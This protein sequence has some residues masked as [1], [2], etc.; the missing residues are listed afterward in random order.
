LAIYEPTLD[1]HTQATTGIFETYDPPPPEGQRPVPLVSLDPEPKTS[2]KPRQRPLERGYVFRRHAA[3]AQ[4]V[5]DWLLKRCPDERL[6]DRV[7]ACGTDAWID[8]SPS[9]GRFRIR[10]TRCGWRACPL[11]RVRWTMQ[12]R[13]RINSVVADVGAGRRKLATLTTRSTAAPLRLQVDR[14]WQCF[15]RLRQRRLWTSAVA[16]SIAVLEVT[17]NAKTDRWH[18]H[19]HVILDA[20]YIEQRALSKAWLSVTLTSRIVD[21]RAVRS[22]GDV[23][24]YLTKYL[25]KTCELPAGTP[26]ERDDELFALY[27]RHRFTRYAGT[28]RPRPDEELWRPDYPKDWQPVAVLEL[29]LEGAARQ[30]ARALAILDAVAR[31][32]LFASRDYLQ[33]RF[34]P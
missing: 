5:D 28:L 7:A 29:I 19:L 33:D 3:A 4:H 20:A 30:D 34:P 13:E 26:P 8:E 9:T 11:C 23:A 25:M 22:F 10:C 17:Y 27:R 16:G 21:I 6:R 31:E 14:L 1:R 24:K 2:E 15:R 32:R 12:Q 18:P